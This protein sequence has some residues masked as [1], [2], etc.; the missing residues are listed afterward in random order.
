M[1]SSPHE[2]RPR[3]LHR[4][5]WEDPGW[6]AALCRAPDLALLT[7]PPSSPAVLAGNDG[8]LLAC[9]AVH[10]W[11]GPCGA[12]RHLPLFGADG[13]RRQALAGGC[14]RFP[15]EGI[16]GCGYELLPE[17]SQLRLPALL[18]PRAERNFDPGF[19]PPNGYWNRS[20]H[21]FL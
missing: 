6:A 3:A 8:S 18:I 15:E 5:A 21:S 16:A 1:P 7:G 10:I 2:R 19:T 13:L 20:F 4:L 17:T 11:R 9:P 12:D 14:E